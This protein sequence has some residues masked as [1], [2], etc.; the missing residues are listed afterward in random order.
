MYGKV[1][2]QG[3][4][5]DKTLYLCHTSIKPRMNIWKRNRPPDSVRVQEI[6][7]AIVSQAYVP[8]IIY[9]FSSVGSRGR[10]IRPPTRGSEGLK[11]V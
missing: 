1:L 10:K 8:G 7:D 3:F 6:K 2:L 5:G 11:N 9:C 4:E